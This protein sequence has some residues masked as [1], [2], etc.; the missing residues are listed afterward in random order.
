MNIDTLFTEIE[1]LTSEEKMDSA[2][3]LLYDVTH[4]NLL[5]GYFEYCEDL[6]LDDRLYKNSQ[7]A[8]ALLSITMPWRRKLVNRPTCILKLESILDNK[9]I[10]SGLR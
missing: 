9:K 4:Q 8:I 10:L 5:N 3:D 1:S 2:L 6:F 7:I